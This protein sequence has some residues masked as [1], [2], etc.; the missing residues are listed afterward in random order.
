MITSA[1]GGFFPSRSLLCSVL[2]TRA[3]STRRRAT[4]VWAPWQGE[5]LSSHG[6]RTGQGAAPVPQDVKRWLKLEK[7][8]PLRHRTTPA[9]SSLGRT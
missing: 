2:S 6:T 8:A 9:L 3:R 7:G 1:V 5:A 4:L